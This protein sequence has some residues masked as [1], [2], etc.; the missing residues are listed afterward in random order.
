[1]TSLI[2]KNLAFGY[3][4]HPVGRNVNL[5]VEPGELTCLLGPNGS[6]KTTLFKTL[7]GL[8]ARQ[9]GS[10]VLNDQDISTLTRTEIARRIAYVPQAHE[11]VFPYTVH[12]MVL[13]GRTAHQKLFSAPGQRD[14]QRVQQTLE[15]LGIGK[16]AQHEFTR[17]SGGQRQL[18]LIAR[19]LAQDAPIIV[20]DEPTA[21]LD[22]GNQVR[23]LQQVRKLANAGLG[24]VLST[25]NPD[26]ALAC[27][28]QVLVLADGG[29]Q[30]AGCPDS[31]LTAELLSKIYQADIR[32]ERLQDGQKVC[33][34][35]FT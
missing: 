14:A 4:R 11:S 26:H 1:M 25:H 17:I 19:A 7:L 34:A 18:T 8:L 9:D 30:A 15:L 33:V 32:L 16:L 29:L 10:I 21:S 6:G 27:A 2:A 22:F 5:A 13:M 3:P 28:S 24:V 23:V 12:D 20:M 35:R 31:V